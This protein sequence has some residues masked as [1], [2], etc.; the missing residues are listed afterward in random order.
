MFY[1][2]N[3]GGNAIY[4]AADEKWHLFVTEIA[5]ARC[6]LGSRFYGKNRISVGTSRA[7]L[8]HLA[9]HRPHGRAQCIC[10]LLVLQYTHT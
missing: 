2:F 4:D 9:V 8:P 5:G 6:G 1:S 10:A 7:S 3:L